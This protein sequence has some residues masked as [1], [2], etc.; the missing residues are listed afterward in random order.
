MDKKVLCFDLDDTL[1]DDNYKFELTFCECMKAIIN[2]LET[3][4]PQI[5]DM[6]KKAREIENHTWKTWSKD[7]LYTP[8]RVANAWVKTYEWYAEDIGLP[9]REHTKNLIES[10]I[11]SNYDPPYFV[12][13]GVVETITYL[14]EKGYEMH[15]VTLGTEPIQRRKLTVSKLI[16]YF[17]TIHYETHDKCKPLSK[18]AQDNGKENVCMIG[19]S[20]RTDI[21]PALSIGIDA[22]Y[23]PRGNWH[24]F[25]QE[26]LNDKYKEIEDIR[27]LI[28]IF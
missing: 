14:K 2:S 9:I 5:D 4:T 20:M 11:L 24:R 19:N 18:V 10:L 8:E 16:R 6:L 23:I 7:K 27:E 1:I 25:K 15:V 22:I 26:P 28:G 13:P 17:D 12:I 3:R 21:N